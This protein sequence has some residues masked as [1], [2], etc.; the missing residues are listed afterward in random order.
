MARAA[1]LVRRE[2]ACRGEAEWFHA[3]TS[4][5]GAGFSVEEMSGRGTGG[6]VA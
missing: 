5:R 1:R 6:Q 3:N 4:Y 2:A